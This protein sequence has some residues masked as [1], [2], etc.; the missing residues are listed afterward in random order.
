MMLGFRF[1]TREP[2]PPPPE[3]DASLFNRAA[4]QLQS[5]TEQ[6][7]QQLPIQSVRGVIDDF[8][9][10]IEQGN[11]INLA[12]GL[13]LGASFTAILNSFVVDILSPGIS[14]FTGASRRSPLRL[15]LTSDGMLCRA[16]PG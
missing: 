8:Y 9:S 7:L 10:F 1:R 4:Q 15:V 5:Y 3:E 14:L 16:E 11:V 13:I 6:T 12:V 2:T